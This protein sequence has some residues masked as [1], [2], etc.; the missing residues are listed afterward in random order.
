MKSWCRTVL[1]LSVG[2]GLRQ[3][4]SLDIRLRV[5]S[6]ILNAQRDPRTACPTSDEFNVSQRMIR[7]IR[8]MATSMLTILVSFTTATLDVQL[9]DIPPASC[10]HELCC[11]RTIHSVFRTLR[12]RADVCPSLARSGGGGG[13]VSN[14]ASWV[15]QILSGV[16]LAIALLGFLW[17]RRSC[18]NIRVRGHRQAESV[19]Q[20]LCSPASV[21][22]CW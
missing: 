14:M 15:F 10:S 19:I 6:S 11:T 1:L 22:A 12:C 18:L 3:R 4:S 7:G 2:E 9:D 13:R 17:M 5:T 8:Y 16:L 20:F 21:L